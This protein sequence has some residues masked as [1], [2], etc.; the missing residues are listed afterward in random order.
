MKKCDFAIVGGDKRTAG[1]AQVFAKRGYNVIC[2][3][4][5]EHP[6]HERIQYAQTLQ[7][8]LSKAP[9]IVCGIPFQKDG[10]LYFVDETMQTPLS[11]FQRMLRKMHKIFAGVIP[12][13]F[14]RGCEKRS[15]NCYDFM[16][17]EPLAIYNAIATAE[18]AVLEA[19]LHKDTHLHQSNALVLGYGRCGKVL[20]DKLKGLSARVTVCSEQPHELAT[21]GSLG[22]Q[23]MPLEKLSKRIKHYEYIFNTI[24]ATVLTESTLRNMHEDALVIDI[25]SNRVGADYRAAE[26]LGR[27]LL[28]CPGLP[29]KY[30]ALSCAENLADYVLNKI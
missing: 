16:L 10:A 12:E 5:T 27:N 8:T 11:E 29:G 22:L 28:F 6:L 17:D 20:A 25:A 3:G 26:T 14:R 4:I 18:G 13:D 23:T 30:A 1:M 7:D 24:P 21:A 19:L 15:I 2:Y 9:V